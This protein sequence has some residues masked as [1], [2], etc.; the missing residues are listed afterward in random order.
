MSALEVAA[1]HARI[2]SRLA[3]TLRQEAKAA[4]ADVDPAR[5]SETWAG[6]IPR[7]ALM[8]AGG[9]RDAAATADSY[10]NEVLAE[11]GISPATAGRLNSSALAGVASDGRDLTSL[12]AQPGITA[13]VAI[14]AGYSVDYAMAA[15][16]ALSQLIAHTQIADAGRVADGVALTGHSHVPGYRRMIVGKTCSRC[17]VLAGK[18]YRWNSGFKRHPKCDCVHIPAQE[19]VDEL[20][21][22]PRK[23]FDSL[24]PAEQ[25]RVFTQSGAK[26]IRDGA[27]IGAVVNARRGA[28]GLA[29]AGARLTQAEMKLLGGGREAGH[30]ETVDVFGRQ[31]FITTEGTTTRGLAGVRL[32]AKESGRKVAG[33]RYRSARPPRLMPESIYQIA[34]ADRGEALRLLKRNGYIL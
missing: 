5:I 10:V 13:K 22:N 27:D 24:S 28:R 29:P 17:V 14:G 19:S 1:D 4:W 18:Y 2:R 16:D 12:L 21:T 25:D 31:L 8:L 9:Q 32:G 15:G 7:L 3:E 11:Q 34:G 26:A 6:Q 30:L 20:R 23:I 33:N